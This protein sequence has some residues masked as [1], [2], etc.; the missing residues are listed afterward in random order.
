MKKL[1][2]SAV[3]AVIGLFGLVSNAS[4]QTSYKGTLS[5]IT[6]NGKHFNNVGEK[7]FTLTQGEGNDYVLSGTVDKIGKMPG[8]ISVNVDVIIN[9]GV[10]VFDPTGESKTTLTVAG[11]PVNLNV[12]SF[13]G[14]VTDNTLHFVLDTYAGWGT[15]PVFPASVTFDGTKQ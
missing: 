8:T 14:T 3:L 13:T 9:N 6:M 2:F 11:I 7:V 5:N 15:L 12:K 4:A 1:M 10:M